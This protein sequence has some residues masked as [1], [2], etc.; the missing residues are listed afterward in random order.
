MTS[1]HI[2]VSTRIWLIIAVFVSH[3]KFDKHGIKV[4]VNAG[5]CE[6][7]YGYLNQ[8]VQEHQTKSLRT[9]GT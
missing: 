8:I 7:I 6:H 9:Y 3:E 5:I 2:F 4:Y 1:S